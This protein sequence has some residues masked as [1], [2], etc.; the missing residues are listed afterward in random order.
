[1]NKIPKH[2]TILLLSLLIQSKISFA[3]KPFNHEY[4]TE[5]AIQLLEDQYKIVL[6]KQQK[7]DIIIGNLS[8]DYKPLSRSYL[9][10][11]YAVDNPSFNK[12]KHFG[13]IKSY[14]GGLTSSANN[15]KHFNFL[16]LGKIIHYVQDFTCPPHVVPV[17]HSSKDNF[18]AIDRK[19]FKIDKISQLVTIKMNKSNIDSFLFT[20]AQTTFERCKD[21]FEVQ[22]T[23][24]STK[25]MQQINWLSFW[26]PNKNK[27][28]GHYG[29]S[30]Q[31]NK[32]KIGTINLKLHKEKKLFWLN[33][34]TTIHLLPRNCN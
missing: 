6:T 1:M 17:F 24:G 29:F 2:I 26:I 10:H 34:Q 5:K 12:I 30:T 32:K 15:S 20:T 19:Q 7:H 25:Q 9:W 4:I 27:K 31:D 14:L 22:V 13:S 8:Q 21:T 28:L 33:H 18:D 23:N 3:Y 16:I 11:F